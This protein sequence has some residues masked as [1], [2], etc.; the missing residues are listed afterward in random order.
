MG[1]DDKKDTTPIKESGVDLHSKANKDWLAPSRSDLSGSS[2][3][4][5][6]LTASKIAQHRKNPVEAVSSTPQQLKSLTPNE[7][8][9]EINRSDILIASISSRIDLQVVLINALDF[10]IKKLGNS[11]I[12]DPRRMTL[13]K[14]LL[15]NRSELPDMYK[16][17]FEAK[18]G[19]D[20]LEKRNP[21]GA[22]Q[23][24]VS[25][26]ASLSTAKKARPRGGFFKADDKDIST[27][28]EELKK[29]AKENAS[30]TSSADSAKTPSQENKSEEVTPPGTPNPK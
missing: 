22:Q 19:R 1:A 24:S 6:S 12:T 2:N 27:L 5:S 11:S 3:A 13:E 8:K 17:F 23:E 30:S 7:Y 21:A 9:R 16:Q 26:T 14:D 25:S 29:L 28:K 15:N 20:E 18:H 4:N 10:Q